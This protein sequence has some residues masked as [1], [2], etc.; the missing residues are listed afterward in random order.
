MDERSGSRRTDVLKPSCSLHDRKKDASE[1]PAEWYGFHNERSTWNPPLRQIDYQK[2]TISIKLM[3][4]EEDHEYMKREEDSPER[5]A[6][7]E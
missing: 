7:S 2:E 1:E 3:N 5:P 4:P 6:E